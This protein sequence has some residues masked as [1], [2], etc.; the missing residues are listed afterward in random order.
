MCEFEC[1]SLCADAEVPLDLW[2]DKEMVPSSLGTIVV[3]EDWPPC[4]CDRLRYILVLVVVNVT[5]SSSSASS[6]LASSPPVSPHAF[7]AYTTSRAL[8]PSVKAVRG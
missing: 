5:G 4:L 2:R 8:S 1:E 7:V 6:P 3:A